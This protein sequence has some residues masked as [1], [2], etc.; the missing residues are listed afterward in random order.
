MF[1]LQRQQIVMT[2][3][4]AERYPKIH[5]SAMHPGWADTPGVCVVLAGHS[6]ILEGSLLLYVV[7]GAGGAG[8]SLGRMESEK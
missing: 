6:E 1:F 7:G 3:K 8:G 2:K 4:W 5:F